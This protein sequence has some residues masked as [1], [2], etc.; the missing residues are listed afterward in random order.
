MKCLCG[1]KESA[2]ALLSSSSPVQFKLLED[3]D[4]VAIIPLLSIYFLHTPVA[5]KG[6]EG[7]SFLIL[8]EASQE[9]DLPF[10]SYWKP[11]QLPL[12]AT[13]MCIF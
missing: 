11:L 3:M 12:L 9:K 8:P 7:K 4:V 6:L 5:S 10:T 2:A 13:K 1:Y